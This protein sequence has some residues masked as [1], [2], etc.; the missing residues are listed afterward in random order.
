MVN[1]EFLETSQ[2]SKSAG[3]R[4]PSLAPAGI[5]ETPAAPFE[6]KGQAWR[7][8]FA[9]AALPVRANSRFRAFEVKGQAWRAIFAQAALPVRANFRAQTP[10]AARSRPKAKAWRAIF[11][12]LPCPFAQTPASAR[13]RPKAKRGEQLSGFQLSGV[14]CS[15]TVYTTMECFVIQYICRTT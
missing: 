9:Q 12:R 8:I 1:A 3:G 13:S 5:L 11:A 14:D 2:R 7:P 4:F 15:V 6:A 10:A